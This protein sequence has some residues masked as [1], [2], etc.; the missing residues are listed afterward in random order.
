MANPAWTDLPEAEAVFSRV[1]PRLFG[2]AYRMMGTVAEAEDA[3]QETWLRWQDADR[4]AV[5]D[6]ASFLMTIVTRI[7][8]NVVQSARARHETYIGPW[9]PEPVDTTADPA[10]GAER[11]AALELATLMLL[12]RLAPPERAAYI[13][14]EAFDY[15]YEQIA[16]TVGVSVPNARQLVS[17]ARKRLTTRRVS[18]VSDADQDRLLRAFVNA[19]RSGD[20]DALEEILAEDV[21]S[22]T[23][24][25]GA[26]NAAQIPVAGRTTVAKFVR[27]FRNRLWPGTT[28]RWITANGRP[29]VLIQ[30]NGSAAAF[31]TI[32]ASEGAIDQVLW[33][34]APDKLMKIAAAQQR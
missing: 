4:A 11:G 32:A 9:L 22:Y 17:R 30:H 29:A 10:L 20:L 26:R 18:P 15:P 12:E 23:D 1:R 5:T 2:V 25:N 24:G 13:L 19:A 6:P 8:L 21:V 16:E 28:L 7:C 14:R 31:L 3:V 34:L 33:V 27:A